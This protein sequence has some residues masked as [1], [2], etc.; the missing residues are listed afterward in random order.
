MEHLIRKEVENII[1][2]EVSDPRICFFTI[3]GVNITPDLK[4]ARIGISFMGTDKEKQN[5][6]K[7]IKSA[8]GYIQNKLAKRL[9][10]KFCPK[11]IFEIDKRKE[12][13][14]EEILREITKE[15]DDK[16]KE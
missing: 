2:T 16:D 4:Y 1:R 11:I 13:R 10:M 3:T 5:A 6:E 15:Q 12:Y 7:G 8:T 9:S 14:I